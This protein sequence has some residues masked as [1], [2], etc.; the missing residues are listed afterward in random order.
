MNRLAALAAVLALGG[1]GGGGLKDAM[2][3]AGAPQA[4]SSSGG[5]AVVRAW[6][7]E[8]YAGQYDRA[9]NLFAP[10]AIVQ[11]QDTILLQ[12]HGDA[13][14]FNRSLPCRA[15]VTGIVH[16][17]GGNLLASFDLFA[18]PGGSCPRGGTARVRFHIRAGRI[19]VWRQLPD[20]PSAPGEST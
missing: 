3:S 8:V 14:A 5:E 1:C 16:E 4:G 2:K 10:G 6:T 13:V 19:E 12:T 20:V 18:G 7:R 15:K 17:R 11:Q 9:A